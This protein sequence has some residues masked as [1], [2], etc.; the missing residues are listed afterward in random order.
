M[1]LPFNVDAFCPSV[2]HIKE[3]NPKCLENNESQH[4]YEQFIKVW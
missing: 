3:V 1:N 4:A 2:V